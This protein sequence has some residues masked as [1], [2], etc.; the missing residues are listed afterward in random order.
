MEDIT[1]PAT[2]AHIHLAPVGSRVPSWSGLAG[3]DASGFANGCVSAPR[4][5]ILA[6]IENP[7]AY[8]VNIHNTDFPA[9]AVRGQLSR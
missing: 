1:L 7:A 8:Y 6:I 9:G 2:A 4:E 3:P 5:G